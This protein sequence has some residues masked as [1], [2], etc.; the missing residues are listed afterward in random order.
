VNPE[1]RERIAKDGL[2]KTTR[3]MQLEKR[4]AMPQSSTFY[5]PRRTSGVPWIAP[6]ESN[7]VEETVKM[8]SVVTIDSKLEDDEPVPLEPEVG[9]P[10]PVAQAGEDDPNETDAESE[11]GDEYISDN[12][13]ADACGEQ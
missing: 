4:A 12:E 1:L 11:L 6:L 2:F 5:R 3:L 13:Q 9:Q 8:L 10:A 7:P